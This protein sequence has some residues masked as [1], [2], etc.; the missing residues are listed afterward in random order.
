VLKNR[1]INKSLNPFFIRARFQSAIIGYETDPLNVLI[2]SSSGQGF[3]GG[4]IAYLPD[5]D[6]LNPFFI[7]ARFQ[8]RDLRQP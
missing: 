4:D 7:R 1:A 8:R 5:G 3:K 2:P 6:G